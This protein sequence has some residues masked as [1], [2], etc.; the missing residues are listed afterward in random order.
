MRVVGLQTV[1]FSNFTGFSEAL[2]LSMIRERE[3]HLSLPLLP[4][5][6]QQPRSPNAFEGAAVQLKPQ[7][8]EL[9]A[10]YSSQLEPQVT[11]SSGTALLS[12]QPFKTSVSTKIIHFISLFQ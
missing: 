10:Y 4:H 9:S 11:S 2:N 1:N 6:R 8:K 12:S 5:D 3:D 7:S